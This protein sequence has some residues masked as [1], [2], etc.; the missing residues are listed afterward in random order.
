MR[1]LITISHPSHA[2]F[3]KESAKLLREKGHEIFISALERGRLIQIVNKEFGG[4]EKFIAGK[5]KGNRFSI[6]LNVNILRFIK[7]LKFSLLNRIDLGLSVGSFTLGGALKILSTPNIQFDDDPERKMNIFFEKLTASKIYF[8]PVIRPAGKIK[9]FN[10]LKEWSHLSPKYYKPDKK[11]LDEF[12]LEP[13]KYIFVRDISTGSLNYMN[14]NPD[15]ILKFSRNL[16]KEFKVVLSLED[17]TNF[18]KYPDDWI[19]INEPVADI[20]SLLYFSRLVISSG[21]SMAR[22]AAMLGVPGIYC[23]IRKMKA[24]EILMN[25]GLLFHSNSGD[26]VKLINDILK[27][28]LILNNREKIRQELMDQWDDVTGL[29]L[30][31]AEIY[32]M[33]K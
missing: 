7:L 15:I 11:Y 16:P 29:I 31:I 33:K 2:N 13:F 28:S 23:G 12:N 3:F 21:D 10:A 26:E 32:N 8:P 17:K 25:K 4:F 6:I 5:H 24:N 20:Y 9:V 18:R 19:I 22:E 30:D 14:Q 27:N 1:I